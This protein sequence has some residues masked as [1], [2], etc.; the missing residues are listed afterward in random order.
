VA[1]YYG[2]VYPLPCILWT[3]DSAILDLPDPKPA[4]THDPEIV[5]TPSDSGD[6]CHRNIH[7]VS[8]GRAEK[9]LYTHAT[10]PEEKLLICTE[11]GPQ[12]FA[13]D[14]ATRIKAEVVSR[15]LQG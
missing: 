3:F 15:M 13:W 12:P 11:A 6:E 9:L 14:E 5:A 1:A 8:R 7:H 10:P 2:H 4:N